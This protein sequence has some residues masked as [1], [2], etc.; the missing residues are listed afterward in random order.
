MNDRQLRSFLLAC[1]TKSLSKAADEALISKPA[2]VQQINLL[3]HEAGFD[4]FVRTRRGVTPTK[5]G[6][7]LAK[8][9]AE[10]LET[11]DEGLSRCRQIA[12]QGDL[13]VRIGCDPTE[14]APFLGNICDA[15]RSSTSPVTIEFVESAYSRQ[16]E[17]LAGDLI[18]ACFFSDSSLV[19]E[20]GLEFTCLYEDDQCCCMSPHD[21]LATKPFVE[22]ADLAGHKLY[23]EPVY[24]HEKQTVALL[25]WLQDND[26]AVE[27]D[28]RPFDASLPTHILIHGGI[29][30]VPRR[31][32]SD[33]VPPL[34]PVP[35]AWPK[36]RFGLV[37]RPHPTSG[38]CHLI[39][40]ALEYF[41]S[42]AG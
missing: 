16:L 19:G 37:H 36:T 15:L 35:L 24:T 21:V 27:I 3:E 42:S 33:C 10:V 26:V 1:T 5:A 30:P 22:P 11:F 40:T 9:A 4:L 41:S 34:T 32:I 25:K 18:D 39:E 2:F 23:I 38:V 12:R 13:T 6:A 8:V 29:I 28:G 20:L 7:E 17:A 14:V 31:Y